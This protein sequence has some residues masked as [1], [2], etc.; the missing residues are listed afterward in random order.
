MQVV[1]GPVRLIFELISAK[2]QMMRGIL[3]KKQYS[4]PIDSESRTAFLV[5]LSHHVQGD[6]GQC[7]IHEHV[8]VRHAPPSVTK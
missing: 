5:P 2:T 4:D 8:I 1:S 6:S 7:R 3:R